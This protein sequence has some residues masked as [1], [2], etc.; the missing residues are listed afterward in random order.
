MTPSTNSR[1]TSSNSL[2]GCGKCCEE[3]TGGSQIYIVLN[4]IYMSLDT[5]A[6]MD[7]YP[8]LLPSFQ[9]GILVITFGLFY[10]VIRVIYNLFFHPLS[11]FPGPRGAACTKWWLAYMELGKGVSLST[12]RAELHQKYGTPSTL[13]LTRIDIGQGDV[14]RIAPNEVSSCLVW[15]V[16]TH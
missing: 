10:A 3:E 14:I 15:G 5:R 4:R 2:L 12:L 16:G 8:L 13:S 11:H 1:V 9:Q 6:N 7:L